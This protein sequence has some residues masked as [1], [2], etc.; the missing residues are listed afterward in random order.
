MSEVDLKSKNAAHCS[1]PWRAELCRATLFHSSEG[2]LAL[3]RIEYGRSCSHWV[4][5]RQSSRLV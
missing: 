3:E 4:G 5:I 2:L 1:K